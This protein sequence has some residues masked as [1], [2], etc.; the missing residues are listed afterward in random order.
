VEESVSQG[1]YQNASEV[2]RAGLCLLEDEENR[3]E[4]LKKAIHEGINS[5]L[6]KDFDPQRTFKDVERIEKYQWLNLI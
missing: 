1:R 3:I 2:I 4:I 6:A 5:G